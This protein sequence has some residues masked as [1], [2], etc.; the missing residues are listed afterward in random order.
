VRGTLPMNSS[1]MSTKRR[2]LDDPTSS[3]M[4]PYLVLH[5]SR[6]RCHLPPSCLRLKSH[7]PSFLDRAVVKSIRPVS[8]TLVAAKRLSTAPALIS[9]HLAHSSD[10]AHAPPHKRTRLT[11]VVGTT[12]MVVLS[13]VTSRHLE[14]LLVVCESKT[15]PPNRQL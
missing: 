15:I 3:P 6:L 2:T 11:N 13:V 4:I 9:K 10:F 14:L 12:A 7:P 8:F 1:G 5:P